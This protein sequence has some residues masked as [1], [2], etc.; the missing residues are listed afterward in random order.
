[1]RSRA[2]FDLAPAALVRRALDLSRGDGRI[3][4]FDELD[5]SPLEEA[6]KLLD[7]RLVEVELRYRASDLGEREHAELLAAVDETLDLFEFLQF[8]Y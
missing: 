8:R 4:L 1:M 2:V 5:L 3:N 7:V 6:V